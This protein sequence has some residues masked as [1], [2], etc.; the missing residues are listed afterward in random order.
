M[1]LHR[2]IIVQVGYNYSYIANPFYPLFY[3]NR[4]KYPAPFHLMWPGINIQ[5]ILEPQW[6]VFSKCQPPFF[7]CFMNQN[8]INPISVLREGL[9]RADYKGGGRVGG[10]RIELKISK[11]QDSYLKNSKM[12]KIFFKSEQR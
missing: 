8:S 6:L 10:I 7:I 2:E 3:P 4:S 1:T 5:N 11:D 9:M 12:K